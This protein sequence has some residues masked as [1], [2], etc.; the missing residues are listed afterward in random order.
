[1]NNKFKNALESFS[2]GLH[3]YYEGNWSK[4]FVEFNNCNLPL[5]DVFKDRT[6]NY[7]CPKD[8]NG[9]WTMTTK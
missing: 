7:K 5:A 9:I 8:W 2:Q 6:K 4:A 3:Y 1:M